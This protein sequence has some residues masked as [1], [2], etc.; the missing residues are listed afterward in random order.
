MFKILCIHKTIGKIISLEIFKGYN[1]IMMNGKREFS[2][3]LFSLILSDN[4][5]KDDSFTRLD[6]KA[7][8]FRY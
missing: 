2:I 8:S 5:E 3:I 6:K 4:D 7:M 1:C